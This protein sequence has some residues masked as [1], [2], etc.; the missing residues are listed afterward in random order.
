MIVFFP[1]ATSPFAIRFP[2]GRSHRTSMDCFDPLMNWSLGRRGGDWA[3]AS[4]IPRTVKLIA[5]RKQKAGVD[6]VGNEEIP[7]YPGRKEGG[8]RN[9]EIHLRRP[10]SPMR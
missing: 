10:T 8:S 6:M 7:E 5:R 1:G 3:R 2:S 4:S 9:F